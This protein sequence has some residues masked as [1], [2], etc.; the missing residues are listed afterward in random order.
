MDFN[1]YNAIHFITSL[2]PIFC[3]LLNTNPNF[4]ERAAIVSM[5]KTYLT[6]ADIITKFIQS[7]I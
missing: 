4:V 6:E 1:N 7:A 2:H 3:V 5:N